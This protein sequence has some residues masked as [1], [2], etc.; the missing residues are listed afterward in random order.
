MSLKQEF[1][2][3]VEN[4]CVMNPMP[5]RLIP[6]WEKF[7]GTEILAFIVLMFSRALFNLFGHI[8][9][10]DFT[11]SSRSPGLCPA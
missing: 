11:P 6:Y 1:I 4:G 8:L 10:K 7:K 9:A 2:D 5:D 3:Y